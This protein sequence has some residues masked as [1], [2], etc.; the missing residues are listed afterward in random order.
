MII[1]NQIFSLIKLINSETGK[2]Q[3]SFGFAVG[4]ILGLTP[5]FGLH[6]IALFFL[7]CILRINLGAVLLSW[8]FFGVIAFPFDNLFHKFGYHLLVNVDSLKGFWI[9]LYN[10][11]I[12]PW[13]KFNN[14]VMLGS[15]VVSLIAFIPLVIISVVL[16]NKYRATVRE[17]IINSKPY[18]ALK[19]TSLYAM[20]QKYQNIKSVVS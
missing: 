5:T 15:F 12:V 13:S 2:Y 8:A 19:A 20:Y 1:L 4:M 14:T 11:P 6:S 16:I 3:I 18:K 17:W 10:M 7:V 9:K